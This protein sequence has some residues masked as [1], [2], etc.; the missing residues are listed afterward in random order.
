MVYL[1]VEAAVKLVGMM[2]L[3]VKNLGIMNYEKSLNES[4]KMN[5]FRDIGGM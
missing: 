3:P 5:A 2:N 1:G 4:R